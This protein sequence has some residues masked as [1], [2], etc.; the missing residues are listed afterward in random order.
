MQIEAAHGEF[1]GARGDHVLA[2]LQLDQVAERREPRQRGFQLFAAVTSKP[3]FAHQLLEVGARVRQLGNVG[4]N[5]RVGQHSSNFT[6]NRWQFT[7]VSITLV[8]NGGGWE[9]PRIPRPP[10][11]YRAEWEAACTYVVRE[12]PMKYLLLLVVPAALFAGQA[13]YARL[14]EFDGKVEVQLRA[15]DAWSAGERNLPLVESAWLRTGASSRLEIELDEGSAWR[16]GPESQVEISDYARLSTGQRVTVLSLDRGVAYF[17]GE[18]GSADTLTLAVPGAR[19]R[20]QADVTVSR[21]SVLEGV[22]RFSCP[23]AEIDVREGQTVRVEPANTARFWLDRE[24]PAMDLDRGNEDRDQRLA[25]ASSGAHVTQRY[26]VVDLDGAGEWV[27][28]D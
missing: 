1:A 25:A 8:E 18:P 11:K 12:F 14:G 16:L 17:T 20:L 27:Q 7:A 9:H 2:A 10:G 21:I 6:C 28:T 13:R 3:Q 26:G 4:D 19:V 5:C 24:V 15:G 23:A 22:V